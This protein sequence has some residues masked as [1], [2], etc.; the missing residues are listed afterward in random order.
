MHGLWRVRVRAAQ[1]QTHRRVGVRVADGSGFGSE[2]VREG[3]PKGYKGD[4]C[5][6]GLE[7]CSG[8]VQRGVKTRAT[9]C[10]RIAQ[11]AC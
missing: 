1:T 11:S 4:G 3:G 8:T 6:G 10:A 5:H 2:R 7:A 9:Y